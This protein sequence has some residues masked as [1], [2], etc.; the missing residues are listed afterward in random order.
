MEHIT[1][2]NLIYFEKYD[3]KEREFEDD[4]LNKCPVN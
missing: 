3:D 2:E 1:K 4:E